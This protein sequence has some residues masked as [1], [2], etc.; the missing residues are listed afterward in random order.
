[1]TAARPG[2]GHRHRIAA[3]AALCLAACPLPDDTTRDAGPAIA[4][5]E[6]LADPTCPWPLIS[7]HRG[8]CGDEPE[9]TLAGFLDCA[10]RG[11]PMVELDTRDTADGVP[12]LMHD[13]DVER[14]TDG[15]T[16]FPGRTDVG[17]LILAEVQ[18]LV[19]QDPRCDGSADDDLDRCRVPSFAQVLART[20]PQ[21][22]IFL[23]YKGGDVAAL[24]RLILEAQAAA[25]V[26]LF[27]AD[28]ARLRDY[29]AA[30]SGG[31]VM[32]RANDAAEL[33]ALLDPANADLE[34]GW[35]HGDPGT[36]DAFAA[37]LRPLG[38]RLYYDVFLDVDLYLGAALHSEDPDLAAENRQIARDNL[39][40]HVAG[41]GRGFGTSYGSQLQRWLFPR[42]FG[43]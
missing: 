16:R 19:V 9:N 20:D 40:A 23:D 15:A 14:T 42:G 11:V 35:I 22:L 36:R 37:R 30:V 26:I 38:V 17:Q 10:A 1:M 34:L 25:R 43:R 39:A 24:A 29:R 2:P 41:G 32:P 5:L 6:C 3:L 27:D 21:S 4:P 12:V 28:L 8:M 33:E 31:L 7:A 18:Q 13:G